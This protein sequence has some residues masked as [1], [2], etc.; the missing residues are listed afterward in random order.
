MASI[1]RHPNGRREI[2]FIGPDQKRRTVRLGKVDQKVAESTRIKVE[3]LNAAT[4]H[5]SSVSPSASQWLATLG[6]TLH[7]RLVRVGLCKPRV[8]V[9]A[10]EVSLGKM[11]DEYIDRRDDVKPGTRLIYDQ[12]R[13]HLARHLGRD[14]VAREV[15]S[16]DASDF[17]R[18]MRRDYSEAY[19]AKMVMVARTFWR[20]AVDRKLV[21]SNVFAKVRAGSQVNVAHHRFIDRPTIERV[22]AA[23]PDDQWKLLLAL[24]RYAGFRCP[25]EHL[26]LTW[27]DVDWGSGRMTVR[28]CKTEH[29]AD[30]GIRIVPIFE[31]LR[32]Y[33]QAVYDQREASSKHVITRYRR[34]NANL[35]TQLMR[36]IRDAGLTP[37]PRL[38]HN[39]RASCQ[40]ELAER[41]PSH[42]VC[43]WI[44]NSEAVARKHYL[45]TTDAH[46][47]KANGQAG[48]TQP[49]ATAGKSGAESDAAGGGHEPQWAAPIDLLMLK[50]REI[51][52]I[53]KQCDSVQLIEWARQDSNL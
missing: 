14:R 30:K 39:L 44:G 31:E 47:E 1:T 29:H 51:L 3:E 15:T 20:D 25:S 6:D 16:A 28:A 40:T 12:A 26:A 8:D 11:L 17:R 27:E 19:T 18:A 2:Q 46:F 42:V 34:G 5:G 4:I 21:D 10:S 22:I 43:G 53:A 50:T 35:R 9:R 48:A 23:C 38:F 32:P 13:K 24:S 41:F 36:Y 37:W 7:G 33:L 52:A 49:T 45:Q